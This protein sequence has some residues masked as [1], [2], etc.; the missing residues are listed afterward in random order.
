MIILGPIIG[1]VTDTSAIILF[2]TENTL[3]NHIVT[4]SLNG[5]TVYSSRVNGGKPQTAKIERL[6]PHTNYTVI[7][8]IRKDEQ[9]GTNSSILSLS[10]SSVKMGSFST[11]PSRICVMSCNNGNHDL[12]RENGDNVLEH[13]F[14]NINP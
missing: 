4:I 9:V 5:I 2:E 13:L 10:S 6:I 14:A 3:D 7:L 11:S 1:H 12:Y 8:S